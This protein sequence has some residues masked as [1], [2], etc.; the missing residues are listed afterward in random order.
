MRVLPS[1]AVRRSLALAL[2]SATLLGCATRD[3]D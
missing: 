1:R 3:D 2:L